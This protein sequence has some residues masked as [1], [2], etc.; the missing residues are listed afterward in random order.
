MKKSLHHYRCWKKA[1]PGLVVGLCVVAISM[2]AS[3]DLGAAQK[4]GKQ[5][6]KSMDEQVQS[7]K[8]RVLALNRELFLL[9]EELLFPATTQVAVFLSL[10]VGKYFKLDSVQLKLDGKVVANH[11]YTPR[12][13]QAME[14]G[15]VHKLHF[16][17]VK[18]GNHQLV[19]FVRG[20]DLKGRDFKLGTKL[21][22]VKAD[23][24]KYIELK[25]VDLKSRR[26]AGFDVKV[27]Q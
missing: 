23:D 16:G 10:D 12:E 24:P 26:Q 6:F 14:K 4:G 22:F 3:P 2:F 20:K 21:D 8:E 15:G 18:R 19:A 13:I 5:S 1:V 9:E 7:L 17:N 25:I 11:L 27:W